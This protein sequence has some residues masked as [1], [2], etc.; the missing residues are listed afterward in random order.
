MLS[1]VPYIEQLDRGVLA[2]IGKEDCQV[3][4]WWIR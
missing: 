1:I 4:L 3:H 2:I